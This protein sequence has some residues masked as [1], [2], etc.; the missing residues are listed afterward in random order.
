MNAEIVSIGTEILLGEL[1]DTNANHIAR[2]LRD[3][4]VNV[5]FITAVGDNLGRI[6]QTLKQALNRSDLV[7]TTGGLGPTVDDVTREAAAAAVGRELVFQPELLQQIADRFDKFGATMSGNNRR[8]AYIPQGAIPVEN[9]VG[10][11]PCYIVEDERGT[12]ISLPGVPREMKYLLEHEILPYLRQR[13]GANII[14]AR[15]LRTAGIGESSLDDKIGDLMTSANPTVG[16]A[17]HMGQTDIRITA[18]AETE[19]E[20]DRMLAKMETK[21]RE[22]VGRHIYGEGQKPV[23]EAV[24]ELLARLDLKMAIAEAGTGGAL[25][26]RLAMRP[27]FEQVVAHSVGYS[28]LEEI[29][30]MDGFSADDEQEHVNAILAEQLLQDE[31]VTIALVVTTQ[32]DGTVISVV[33]QENTHQ[34]IYGYGGDETQAPVWAPTWSLSMAWRMIRELDKKSLQE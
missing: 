1:V 19:D 21:V 33:T 2:N 8:Q 10:T 7:I 15:V 12:I 13:V 20:A 28:S 25:R 24:L 17:A 16:L 4:G 9:P 27:D 18:R 22:R 11:A 29:K 30:G 5:F 34:R 14:K 26:E 3:I 31:A 6:T 23:E 32:K